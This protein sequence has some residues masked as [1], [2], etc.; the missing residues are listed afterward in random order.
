[1]GIKINTSHSR[2]RLRIRCCFCHLKTR[3]IFCFLFFLSFF[4]LLSNGFHLKRH[5]VFFLFFSSFISPPF[6]IFLLN[7]NEYS[8]EF[9]INVW[10]IKCSIHVSR[11]HDHSSAAANM[12]VFLPKI[13]FI[14]LFFLEFKSL[15]VAPTTNRL[16]ITMASL[17]LRLTFFLCRVELFYGGVCA[18]RSTLTDVRVVLQIWRH[19][20][21]KPFGI[22]LRVDIQ[23]LNF[24]VCDLN[25]VL[26]C[27]PDIERFG[28]E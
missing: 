24:R 26:G 22:L 9:L 27:C 23:H 8:R 16:L 28:I 13:L 15:T 12:R 3:R 18:Q 17:N 1:M 7:I 4:F 21:Q 5:V 11:I 14:F 6:P 19:W 2:R 10:S 20:G 25:G